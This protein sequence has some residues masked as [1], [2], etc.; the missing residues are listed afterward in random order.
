MASSYKLKLARFS[1]K[2][3]IQD[4]AECGNIIFNSF[5]K[6]TKIDLNDISEELLIVETV[7]TIIKVGTLL[8]KL[9]AMARKP[10]CEIRVAKDCKNRPN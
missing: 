9:A 6:L 2:L 4:G 7:V 10:R 1:A 5:R 8:F 3:R